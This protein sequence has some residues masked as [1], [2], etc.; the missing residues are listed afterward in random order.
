MV[1]LVTLQDVGDINDPNSRHSKLR[2]NSAQGYSEIAQFKKN[3]PLDIE[4]TSFCVRF[5]VVV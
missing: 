4:Q 5:V 2:K 1:N 3:K